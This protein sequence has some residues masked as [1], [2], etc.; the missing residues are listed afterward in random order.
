[1]IARFLFLLAI[2]AVGRFLLLFIAN[3][4]DLRADAAAEPAGLV[5]A[6]LAL[7][8][9]ASSIPAGW[10]ADRV[11]RRAL[12]MAGAILACCGIGLLPAASKVSGLL[13]IG[14]LIALGS[15]AFGAGSW[16]L[17]TDLTS[18][19]DS[20]RLMGIANLGTAGAAAAAG[21]FG[22]LI[23][24]GNRWQAMGGYTA[25][26]AVA[27]ALALAGGLISWR[28]ASGAAAHPPFP[29]EVPS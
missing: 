27:A 13:V 7:L 8:T 16:A 20:G 11:G 21:G 9:A 3:R 14:C 25:A 2:F 29:S 28:P 26:F 10:L 19:T 4:F 6:L 18:S 24:A 22:L 15:G 5:L 12:M 1:V 17:L 23:D